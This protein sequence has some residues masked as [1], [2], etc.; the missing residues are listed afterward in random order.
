ME[1]GLP[2]KHNEQIGLDSDS[3]TN[4]KSLVEKVRANLKSFLTTKELAT[5]HWRWLYPLL[6]IFAGVY[7]INYL[8]AAKIAGVKEGK[9]V[10]EVGSGWPFY[11]VYSGKV[12]SE[13]L[14]VAL[15]I[16]KLIQG[17]SYK[18]LSLT[19]K[20]PDEKLVVG[21]AYQL[22]FKN[23]SFDIVLAHNP[24]LSPVDW[25]IEA[26]RIL[27]PGGT[28]L[29]TQ[30][31]EPHTIRSIFKIEDVLKE[32][33]K[34]EDVKFIPLVPG[35]FPNIFGMEHFPVLPIPFPNCAVVAQK[36]LGEIK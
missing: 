29:V 32:E 15:D 4:I 1:T 35:F 25:L 33:F 20:S 36:P 17:A 16:D 19:G 26:N 21:N 24:T 28:I 8:L 27:K 34:F 2:P 31:L 30:I 9:K 5:Q 14:F 6:R 12:G 23:D 10:L 7:P 18:L 22:P 3:Q 13:G 11:R